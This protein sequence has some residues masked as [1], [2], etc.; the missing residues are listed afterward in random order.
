MSSCLY[1]ALN[2]VVKWL[3]PLFI[4]YSYILKKLAEGA[5]GTE[6]NFALPMDLPIALG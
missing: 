2:P 1:G 4:I 3:V 6:F 5:C